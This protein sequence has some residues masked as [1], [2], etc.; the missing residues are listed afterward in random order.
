VLYHLSHTSSPFCSSYFGDGVL[1]TICLGWPQTLWSQPPQELG[2]QTWATVSGLKSLYFLI[3]LFLLF[4]KFLFFIVQGCIVAFTKV[5]KIYHSWIHSLH[6]SPLSLLPYSWKSFNRF[7]FSIFIHEYLIF[8]PYSASNTFSLYPPPPTDTNS[9]QDLFCLPVLVLKK[10]ILFVK[11][12]M[13]GVSLRHFHVYMY[14][15]PNWL[16]PSIFLLSILVP[17]LWWFQQV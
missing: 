8:P 12:A 9:R 14:Y 13:Q 16:I 1:W 15:N 10:K 5:L 4:F 11:I 17:F 2:L 3:L 6:H 7:H